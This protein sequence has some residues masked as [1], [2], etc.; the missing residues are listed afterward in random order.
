MKFI[1]LSIVKI[2]VCLAVGIAIGDQI[3]ISFP[4]LR[5]LPYI[6]LLLF[7]IWI[8]E[9]KKLLQNVLFGILAYVLFILIGIANIQSRT[10]AF[11][12]NHYSKTIPIGKVQLLHLKVKQVLK[13]D[14]YN[15]KYIVELY[16]S[17]RQ[18]TTG[19]LILYIKKDSLFTAFKVDQWLLISSEIL[20]I[21]AALNPN[22]FDYKNYLT[23]LG[24]F[25]QIRSTK[26]N[27]LQIS[28][29]KTTLTGF[30]ER[31][32][33]HLINKLAKTS[34]APPQLAI[35]HALV[36][37]QRKDISKEMYA[38]YAAAGAVHILAV[39]GL[40]VGI[41][42]AILSWLLL[43]LRWIRYGKTIRS[44]LIVLLLW[45]FALLAG[46]SP[47]VVRAVTM[48]SFFALAGMLDRPTNTFNTLFLSFL[49]LLLLQPSWL[50]HVGFQ[51]SYL[52]VFFIIWIQPILYKWYQPNHKIKR[53]FWGI[54]T[55]TVAAQ[56]GV[57]PLSIYY[58]HQFPGLFFVT[59]LIIL[60]FLGLLLCIGILVVILAFLE[61]LPH[62]L[63]KLYNELITFLNQFI[64]W[65]ANQ[66]S[67]LFLDISFSIYQLITAYLFIISSVW[68]FKI[69]SGKNLLVLTTS[70]CLFIS[71]GV[72]Q[73]HQSKEERLA[74][75]H[76]G[77]KTLLG[78]QK[79]RKL[80]LLQ[81]D[82]TS[83]FNRYPIHSYHISEHLVKGD[84][85]NLPVTFQY[86]N[87]KILRLDS[88]GIYDSE[89][90]DIVLLTYSPKVN[91]ERLI[92]RVQPQEII[93]DG[94]NYKSYVRRWKA[95][96]MKKNIKFYY[97]GEKGAYLFE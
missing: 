94:S 23:R 82:S 45:G 60:P 29:G 96:C 18:K 89:R 56:L 2:A 50:F 8:W 63:G 90:M 67:F 4:M 81:S 80:H 76:V 42:F 40:H 97:T 51:L 39:S 1:N 33:N 10:P 24:V 59:N 17:N 87:K 21:Q 52:A 92:D 71:V 37:G 86:K 32:R 20:E 55:V 62:W 14:R 53:F 11:S 48:F 49:L 84:R 88:L 77:R 83:Y 85:V 13:S 27:V 72:L 12:K 38:D 78:H 15:Q 34:I 58:F 41:L 74:L 93:A 16:K 36:L 44:I 73:K 61:V 7:I 91:L 25:H 30:S 75:F 79:D 6:G 19:R 31:I 3:S 66:N 22:Q 43:P 35:I 28:E 95:T 46:L 26:V 54:F 57:A 64:S 68:V 9:R 70:L 5:L 47:S 69:K 65:I